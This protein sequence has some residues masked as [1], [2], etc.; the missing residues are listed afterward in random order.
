MKHRYILK[1][2]YATEKKN[3]LFHFAGTYKLVAFKEITFVLTKFHV[4]KIT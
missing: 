1:N 3:S 4:A 2:F